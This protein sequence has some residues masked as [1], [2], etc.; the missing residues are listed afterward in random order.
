[1]RAF[2]RQERGEALLGG[3]NLLSYEYRA[4]LRAFHSHPNSPAIP[5]K[6]DARLAYDSKLHYLIVS[7]EREPLL[8][9]FVLEDGALREEEINILQ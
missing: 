4:Q 7:L 5:S 9:S 3:K 2:G 1:M 6:E 8:K